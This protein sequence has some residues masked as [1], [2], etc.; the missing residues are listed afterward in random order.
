MSL[1]AETSKLCQYLIGLNED[2]GIKL[3]EETV[4]EDPL[5]RSDHLVWR[6]VERDGVDTQKTN[7]A[8]PWRINLTI[9][10]SLIVGATAG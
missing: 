5:D 2:R 6:V 9:V 7:D 4:V 3:I 10:G 1:R 8:K